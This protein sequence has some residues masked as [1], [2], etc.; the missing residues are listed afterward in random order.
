MRGLREGAVKQ[1]EIVE[2]RQAR[3]DRRIGQPYG[4]S[5]PIG[6]EVARPAQ[7]YESV[8][9]YDV[10]RQR[11]TLNLR[12]GPHSENETQILNHPC[13]RRNTTSKWGICP[14]E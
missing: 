7:P 2:F 3:F 6:E 1:P 11:W 13:K 10:H 12:M 9:V 8:V 14:T 5:Q 4:L